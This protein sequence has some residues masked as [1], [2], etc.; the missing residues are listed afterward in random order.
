M[1]LRTRRAAGESLTSLASA[2]NTIPEYVNYVATGKIH[3]AV[4]GPI[5]MPYQVN[6]RERQLEFDGRRM[7]PKKWAEHVGLP[8]TTIKTRLHRGW[9]IEATLTTPLRVAPSEILIPPG[10]SIA[11]VALN[12]GQFACIDVETIPAIQ[13]KRWYVVKDPKSGRMY[14]AAHDEVDGEYQFISMRTLV[15]GAKPRTSYALNGNNLD[16]RAANLRD[17]SKAQS[18]WRN[19]RRKDNKTG[20]T[21][22]FW[23]KEKQRFIAQIRTNGVDERLGSFTSAEEAGAAVEQAES[24]LRGEF[25]RL[26]SMMLPEEPSAPEC[27][28]INES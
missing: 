7:S 5:T 6:A 1:E 4:G 9:S 12:E 22:V 23:S 27:G 18:S 24:R 20:Y 14:P 17:V 21:G 3:Q 19:R 13:N 10:P 16:C 25:A 15:L 11:Y 28:G 2:F 8:L 26:H